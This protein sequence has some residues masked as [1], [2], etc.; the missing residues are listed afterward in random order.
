MELI[1]RGYEVRVG[2]YRDREIDF[3][4]TKGGRIEYYQV[5]LS[6]MDE[7]TRER[8][9]RSIRD[10]KDYSRRMILTTDTLGLGTE[11]GVDVVNVIDWLTDT[12]D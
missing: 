12:D 6:M 8:E 1:R 5:C 3:T 11:N 4:A 7:S 9:F 10:L 2:S